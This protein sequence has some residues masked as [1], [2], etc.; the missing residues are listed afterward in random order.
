MG[1]KL[2]GNAFPSLALRCSLHLLL[3]G[4]APK[5]PFPVTPLS[6]HY[7]IFHL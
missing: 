5:T 1:Q 2:E 7:Y 3:V 4:S 6:R